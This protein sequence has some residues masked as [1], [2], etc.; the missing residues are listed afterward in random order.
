MYRRS[1]IDPGSR[2]FQLGRNANQQV[3]PADCSDELNPDW[4][5]LRGPMQ[6][7]RDRRLP[8]Q[9]EWAGEEYLP[10]DFGFQL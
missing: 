10:V 8:G 7:Q 2:L 9:I 3:L 4:Q 6:R 5:T 1:P